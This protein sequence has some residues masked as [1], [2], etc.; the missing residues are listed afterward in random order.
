MLQSEFYE[1]TKVT[2]DSEQYKRVEAVYNEVEMDKDE[3]CKEWHKMRNS[4]LMGEIEDA[5]LALSD[6]VAA[7]QI[8]INR[9][10]R[11][12]ESTKEAHMKYV[13]EIND[14]HLAEREEFAKRIICSLG[15]EKNATYDIIEEEFGYAFIIKTKHEAKIALSNEEIS[16][17]VGKL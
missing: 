12:A 11:E 5:M 1:R 9:L 4:K 17:M 15:E 8:Q 6:K 13:K 16:Y 3:F 7:Y 14:I 2:L 10:K